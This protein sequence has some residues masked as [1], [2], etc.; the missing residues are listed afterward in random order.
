MNYYILGRIVWGIL[1][2][3]WYILRYPHER[4]V[5][6]MKLSVDRMPGAERL[7]LSLS[8]TGIGVIPALYALTGFP[9]FADR[10]AWPLA[11]CPFFY[12]SVADPNRDLAEKS[13]QT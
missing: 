10:P 1:G 3:G 6:K 2:V 11:F 7:R 13:K 4:R 8:I 12:S 9:A 5:K